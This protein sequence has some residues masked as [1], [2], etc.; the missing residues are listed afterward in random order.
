ME[1]LTFTQKANGLALGPIAYKLMY[2]DEGHGWT[3]E[4]TVRAIADYIR[5]LRLKSL[6]PTAKLVPTREIDKV[7]HCHILDTQKYAQ[8]CH[9]L[10]GRFIH[11]FPYYGLRGKA[12]REQLSISFAE[13]QLLSEQ[14]QDIPI[15]EGWWQQPSGCILLDKQ[16]SGCVLLDN[17]SQQTRPSVS[18]NL[19]SVF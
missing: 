15:T 14:Y 4:Q 8:D 13:T 6:H 12:D 7:W 5:F 19:K 11:H 16:L 9:L 10:F 18:L 3:Y 17:D 2:S 1:E